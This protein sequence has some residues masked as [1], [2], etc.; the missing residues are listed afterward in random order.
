MKVVTVVRK[1]I[2]EHTITDV[3]ERFL[4]GFKSIGIDYGAKASLEV[5]LLASLATILLIL[6]F[7]KEKLFL[8]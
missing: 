4:Y 5:I 6:Y 1:Y 2:S 7:A 3:Y 8:N